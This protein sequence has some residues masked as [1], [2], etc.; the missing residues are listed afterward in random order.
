M[1]AKTA[2]IGS[3]HGLPAS[4]VDGGFSWSELDD[5]FDNDGWED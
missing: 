4:R 3:C 1:D 2:A 5:N